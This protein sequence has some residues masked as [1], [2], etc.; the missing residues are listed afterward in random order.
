MSHAGTDRPPPGDLAGHPLAERFHRLT[1]EELFPAVERAG[2]RCSGTFA[3]LNSY[4]NR[5][6]QF[7][8][9]DGPAVVAKFYRPGRWSRDAVLEEHGFLSAL[10]DARVPVAC[11]LPLGDGSTIGEA[12]GILYAVYPRVPGR[13]PQELDDGQLKIL[14]ELLARMHIVGTRVEAPGRPVLGPSTY[15]REDLAWL[16]AHDAI[17]TEASDVYAATVQALVARIE[18]MFEG[19]PCQRIHGDCHP[20]NL[21][22]SPSGP[23]F[24][25]F[26]DLL[27]GPAVQDVWMLAPSADQEGVRQ[28]E[29]I[30]EAYRKVR[31]FPA[32]WLR[33]VEPLRALRFVHY[34]T[35]I[36]RRWLDPQFRRTFGYFG[37][38][39]YWQREIQDLREQI[40]RIDRAS[41]LSWS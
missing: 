24:V 6:Y 12:A 1:P 18:P 9:D 28:R 13:V 23:T 22:W 15:G 38:V 4:E 39:L 21:L 30:A 33:L 29:V 35:W 10:R 27:T 41:E 2:V 26:D 31:D 34:S 19:V 16:L 11:P 40:A 36:A 5:V 37:D 3:I 8:V 20:G 14:G 7:D 25:D 32:R 17:P